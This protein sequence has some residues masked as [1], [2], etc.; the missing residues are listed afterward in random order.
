MVEF[1]IL[2]DGD[3]Y[4]QFDYETVVDAMRDA[5]A[6]RAA[7]TLEAPPRWYV[8]A[9]EGELVFTVGAATGPT[10]AAGFRVYETHGSGEDHTQLVVVF[11]ATTGTVE[12]LIVGHATGSLRTGGIGGVA[13][14]C[15]AREDCETLGVL[16]AGV[17]ARTQVGAAC[18][19]RDFDEVLIYSPT[20]E[21]RTAFAE[22]AAEDVEPP[23]RAVDDPKPVV[24]E[25][26]ALVCATDSTDPVF[27]PDWLEAG[28]H[29]TTIGPRFR[30]AHELPLEVV[31]RADVIATDS[32]S[33]VDAYDREYLVSGDDYDRMVELADVLEHPDLGRT[34]ADEITLFCS[35]GL[36]GTEVVLGTRFLEDFA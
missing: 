34:D 2:T 23:V 36:A 24:R 26:D 6:E 21:S 14:D 29:V 30:D 3:V 22:T 31:N 13:I 25:A 33:Q 15:L 28:T 5:F 11:D 18:A 8:E 7:G 20:P 32:L 27:D 35:V 12:G 19:V 17:Q 4:S 1:P 16:G 10:N 9:G